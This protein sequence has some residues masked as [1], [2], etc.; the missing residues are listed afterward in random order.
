[1]LYKRSTNKNEFADGGLLIAS[2][3]LSNSIL[4]N[5]FKKVILNN[6]RK[7]AKQM[8]IDID[9]ISFDDIYDEYDV[10]YGIDSLN[11][12]NYDYINSKFYYLERE[13]KNEIE[14]NEFNNFWLS[15]RFEEDNTKYSD[16]EWSAH[17]LIT[18]VEN[19]Y[20]SEDFERAKSFTD[21]FEISLQRV[22]YKLKGKK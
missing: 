14:N 3:I 15:E 11:A 6:V 16:A 21:L 7:L 9:E 17:M 20:K 5:D 12:N 1:M 22:W 19:F 8:T 2:H 4:N 18:E 13:A 10:R